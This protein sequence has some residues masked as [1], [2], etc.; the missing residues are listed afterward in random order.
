[1][2][3]KLK[4][5]FINKQFITFAFI[6]GFNTVASI[7]I[8]M[9]FISINVSVAMSSLL[10][11]FISMIGSYLFN[12]KLT[13]KVKCT[14]KNFIT[15]PISYLPG[16]IVN[17]IITVLLVDYFGVNDTFAKAFALPITIPLNFIVMSFVVKKTSK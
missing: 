11:D 8:Y 14:F 9:L 10:G 6:G 7:L 12:M 2:I 5:K 1:M 15:F 3:S 16:I 17:M 13:Y 4:E